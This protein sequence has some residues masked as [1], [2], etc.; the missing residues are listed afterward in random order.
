MADPGTEDF[1]V[2]VLGGGGAGMSAAINAAD[3][4]R[5]VALLE[6]GDRLGGST[7]LAGGVFYAAG[8]AAQRELGIKDSPDAMY[9]DVLALNGDSVCKPALRRLCDEAGGALEWLN[10]LGVEFPASRL[11]SPNGRSVPRSHEPVGFGMRIAECLDTALSQRPVD[12]VRRARAEKVLLSPAGRASGVVVDGEP[13]SC[14]SVV[15][16]TGGFGGDE[17]WVA[18]MLPKARRPGDWVWHVGNKNNRGDGLRLAEECGAQIE[19]IDSGL[20]LATPNFHRDLEVLGP[21]WALMVNLEGR[22]FTREDGAYWEISEALEAQPESRAYVI[23]DRTMFE[24][25]KPHPRVLEALA[26]GVITVSWVPRMFEEQLAKGRIIEAASIEQ[27]AQRTGLPAK[28]LSDTVARYNAAARSGQDAEYDKTAA[29]LKPV[30][31]APFYA[32]EVRPAILTVTGGGVRIDAATRVCSPTGAAIPGLFAAG[33]TVGNLY[34]RHY[35]GT[36]YAIASSITFGRVAGQEA[37]A[38]SGR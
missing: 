14:R 23:F 11:S 35:A 26:A 12:V 25:A 18:R 27:L 32:V 24:G 9:R 38:F 17:A 21:D 30:E 37:A 31:T 7:A 15:L 29:S 1:D 20:L 13:I 6:A 28:T 5:R 2:I 33:E 4:G 8:T 36:G 10:S 34:G 22:R 16:A 3:A 19:G